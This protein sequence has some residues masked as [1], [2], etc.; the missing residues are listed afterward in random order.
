MAEQSAS[1]CEE[2]VLML[3]DPA[4]F[5]NVNTSPFFPPTEN[6][7]SESQMVLS[8]ATPRCTLPGLK[9]SSWTSA[10][11]LYSKRPLLMGSVHSSEST[12]WTKPV[13]QIEQSQQCSWQ[14]SV[15]EL[16]LA[17]ERG[18]NHSIQ[19]QLMSTNEDAQNRTFRSSCSVF[20]KAYLI[21]TQHSMCLLL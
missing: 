5:S 10:R 14:S 11:C 15:Q 19:Q 21:Y 3:G 13:A 9:P 12:G 4:G 17:V 18:G 7:L 6:A 2:A 1:L 16:S 8:C 20:F